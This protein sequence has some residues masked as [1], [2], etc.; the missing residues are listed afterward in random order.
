M[1][2]TNV[3]VIICSALV[4]L[5]RIPVTVRT[6]LAFRPV[7]WEG[8]GSY[9][10]P[11]ILALLADIAPLV[12][13]IVSIAFASSGLTAYG[14]RVQLV[15][16]STLSIVDLVRTTHTMVGDMSNVCIR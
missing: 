14:L 2:P 11:T 5:I 16:F 7:D 12:P 13:C 6:L 4:G 8:L 1:H 9:L 3:V 15:T 10:P